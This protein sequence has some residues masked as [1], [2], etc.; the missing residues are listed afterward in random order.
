MCCQSKEQDEHSLAHNG[1]LLN[2][3]TVGREAKLGDDC[4]LEAPTAVETLLDDASKTAATNGVGLTASTTDSGLDVEGSRTGL[5][6][7]VTDSSG[8]A[9]TV[10]DSS[11]LVKDTS[12]LAGTE[13]DILGLA[14]NTKHCG[15]P[16]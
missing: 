3:D 5:A 1:Q 15:V 8:L 7:T 6:G 4:G 2:D 12:G 11:G 10:T 16:F 13:S 14:R 9:G